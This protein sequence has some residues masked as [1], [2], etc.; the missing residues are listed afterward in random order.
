MPCMA[1]LANASIAF[2]VA[3]KDSIRFRANASNPSAAACGLAVTK[4]RIAE[5]CVLY[6]VSIIHFTIRIAP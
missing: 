3:S 2:R 1:H 5:L 6:S 4:R